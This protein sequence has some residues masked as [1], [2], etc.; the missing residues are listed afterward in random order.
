MMAFSTAGDHVALPGRY[1]QRA[2]VLDGDVGDLLIG[3]SLP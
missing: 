1:G 3:T 2:G